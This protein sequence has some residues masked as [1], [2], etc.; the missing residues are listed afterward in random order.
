MFV[1]HD[2]LKPRSAKHEPMEAHVVQM[3][4]HAG[5]KLLFACHVMLILYVISVIFR[6]IK[7]VTGIKMFTMEPSEIKRFVLQK[8]SSDLIYLKY[9]SMTLIQREQT[10]VIGPGSLI[11]I[12]VKPIHYSSDKYFHIGDDQL[13]PPEVALRT[14][15]EMNIL[16]INNIL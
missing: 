13:P 12:T 10:V 8:L 5:V 3:H 9:F 11:T 6:W 7:S 15:P 2:E 14:H 1:K 4:T 16:L